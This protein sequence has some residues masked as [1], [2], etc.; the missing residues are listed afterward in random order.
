MSEI[1]LHQCGDSI[2]CLRVNGFSE[3]FDLVSFEGTLNDTA[4]DSGKTSERWYELSHHTDTPVQTGN[5]IGK[6]ISENL[7]SF[8]TK[9][10]FC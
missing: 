1:G 4:L 8:K 2:L 7:S 3:P 10:S 5:R 6:S 9:L